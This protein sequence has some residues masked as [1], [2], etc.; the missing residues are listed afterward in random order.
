[1]A[2]FNVSYLNYYNI[3]LFLSLKCIVWVVKSY[4]DAVQ[5]GLKLRIN[6]KTDL[7]KKC[8][9]FKNISNKTTHNVMV[10][11]SNKLIIIIYISKILVNISEKYIRVKAE[12]E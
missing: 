4:L 6:Y 7:I 11:M 5:I 3:T 10:C 8:P 9:E 12:S 2:T 1:M